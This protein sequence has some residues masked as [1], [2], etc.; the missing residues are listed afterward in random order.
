MVHV[1]SNHAFKLRVLNSDKK[2]GVHH[3]TL[4]EDLLRIL[5]GVHCIVRQIVFG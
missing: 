3:Q 2:N 1:Y 4:K 5:T